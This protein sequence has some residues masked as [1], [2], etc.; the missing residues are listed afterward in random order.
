MV[1][2]D[3]R[4]WLLVLGV[5]CADPFTV[6][7][8]RLGPPR[9]AALGVDNGF[10]RAAVWSG[11][12]PFHTVA[13]QLVWSVDGEEVGEGFGVAVPD[14]GVLSVAVTFPSGDSVDGVVDIG[15]WRSFD[16]TLAHGEAPASLERQDRA[17][18]AVGEAVDGA[19]DAGQLVRLVSTSPAGVTL[20]WMLD[21][22]DWTVL[23]LDAVTADVVAAAVVYDDGVIDRATPGD[24]GVGTGMV[25]AVDG[26]GG[27]GWKWW[28]IV[29]DDEG[30]W[31]WTNGRALRVTSEDANLAASASHVVVTLWADPSAPGG[32]QV[33]ELAVGGQLEDD[34]QTAPGPACA[35]AGRPFSLDY[36]A[37]GRCALSEIDGLRVVL[38]TP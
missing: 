15:E 34:L 14:A 17:K 31:L 22:A 35:V 25:L 28:D 20:R 36:L 38:E 37:E 7:R 10:A 27:N 5:G 19:V 13:P 23:E 32:V 1:G 3:M 18:V 30:P 4:G 26:A 8:H 21:R 9:L 33:T 12:G 29:F 2:G 6:E 16:L 11:E 24:G